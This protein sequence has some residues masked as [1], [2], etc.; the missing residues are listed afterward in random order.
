MR[1]AGKGA[2]YSLQFSA[3]GALTVSRAAKVTMKVANK[4]VKAYRKRNWTIDVIAGQQKDK[5][6]SWGR[7]QLNPFN[8]IWYN[9]KNDK[10]KFSTLVQGTGSYVFDLW[11]AH[12]LTLR[13]NPKYNLTGRY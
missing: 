7:Y 5:R 13:N 4:L 8:G 3:G 12:L 6:T 2:N 9:L 11:M 1:S 10:D